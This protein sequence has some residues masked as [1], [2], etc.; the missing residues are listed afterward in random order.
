MI[1]RLCKFE[2]PF[3]NVVNALFLF[4]DVVVKVFDNRV[5][6]CVCVLIVFSYKCL[7]E[8]KRDLKFYIIVNH[9]TTAKIILLDR[10]ILN[11]SLFYF[12][13]MFTEE[14]SYMCVY[15]CACAFKNGQ[16]MIFSTI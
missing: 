6:V 9:F 1:F 14:F 11:R 16:I 5:C 8:I 7:H 15:V 10:K 13:Q 12:M 4:I 2:I 3:H